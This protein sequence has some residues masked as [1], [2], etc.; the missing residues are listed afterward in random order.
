MKDLGWGSFSA[1]LSKI[2]W[3]YLRASISLFSTLF[4]WYLW[5]FLCRSTAVLIMWLYNKS[6]NGVYGF[7]HP[8]LFLKVIL[9]ILVFL[10]FHVNFRITLSI[11]TSFHAGILVGNLGHLCINLESIDIF[12]FD[13]T[14]HKH[15]LLNLYLNISLFYWCECYFIFNFDAYIFIGICRKTIDFC[16]FFLYPAIL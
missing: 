11:S 6:W 10:P 14:N 16:T 13:H 12:G 9:A 2:S 4:N 7:S 3:A 5:L 1:P 8:I 15:A